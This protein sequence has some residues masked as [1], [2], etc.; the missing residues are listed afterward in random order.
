MQ[1]ERKATVDDKYYVYMKTGVVLPQ[2]EGKKDRSS[3]RAGPYAKIAD[4]VNVAWS[5]ARSDFDITAKVSI[6]G[7]LDILIIK[8]GRI[9]RRGH[10]SKVK[11]DA[12]RPEWLPSEFSSALY[13]GS[14]TVT[15]VMPGESAFQTSCHELGRRAFKSL[16]VAPSLPFPSAVA[17]RE[18]AN[19]LSEYVEAFH[20]KE[21]AGR[22]RAAAGAAATK[23]RVATTALQSRSRGTVAIHPAALKSLEKARSAAHAVA[24][25]VFAGIGGGTAWALRRCAAAVVPP[26][27][28]QSVGGGLARA[29]GRVK[30]LQQRLSLS[31]VARA[32]ANGAESVRRRVAVNV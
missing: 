1:A 23:A 13:S 26:A 30:E 5:E 8:D 4:K 16:L 17:L 21:T 27:V 11:G 31:D 19:S 6:R 18:W 32:A 28:G 29:Q 25:D 20:F 2:Q 14:L 24:G 10:V 7:S 9:L 22:A 12:A 15:V 3:N